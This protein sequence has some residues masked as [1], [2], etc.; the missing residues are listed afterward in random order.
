MDRAH[1]ELIVPSI[2]ELG[3]HLP[4]DLKEFHDQ[5]GC[6]AAKLPDRPTVVNILTCCWSRNGARSVA[7]ARCAI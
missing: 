1:W 5:A 2:Y 6:V 3:G 4:N 7:G